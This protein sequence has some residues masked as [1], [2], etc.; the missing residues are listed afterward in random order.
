LVPLLSFFLFPFPLSPSFF[1]GLAELESTSHPVKSGRRVPAEEKKGK[2]RNEKK[3]AEK[4]R[5]QSKK[6]LRNQKSKERR[7]LSN[8]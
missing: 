1:S 3:K 2:K 5:T 6:E 7:F 4:K 8:N